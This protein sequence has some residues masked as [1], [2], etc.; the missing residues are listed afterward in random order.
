MSITELASDQD[1]EEGE[2]SHGLHP[3]FQ[4]NHYEIRRRFFR[5]GETFDL[6]D[7]DDNFVLRSKREPLHIKQYFHFYADKDKSQ[8]LLHFNT[9]GVPPQTFDVIDP[10]DGNIGSIQHNLSE[11][12]PRTT[13]DITST[14]GSVLGSIRRMKTG[15][16]WH[17]HGPKVL[18]YPSYEIVTPENR[19]LA[20]L[21]R[22][23][24]LT[25]YKFNYDITSN[26][27]IDRRL[28][29]AATMIMTTREMKRETTPVGTTAT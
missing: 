18:F 20:T 4:H 22:K 14:D 8:E 9:R 19:I 10:Q 29:M 26:P 11:S 16:A 1:I 12:I 7:S 6:F 24:S 17:R 21:Q 23:M 2:R 13:W 27:S 3:S 25:G 28:L 5:F 15:N